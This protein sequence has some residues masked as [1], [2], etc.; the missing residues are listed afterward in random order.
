MGYNRLGCITCL[1]FWVWVIVWVWTIFWSRIGHNYQSL[2][3]V[4]IIQWK[5]WFYIQER[6]I[7][8]MDLGLFKK[9]C[10]FLLFW[11]VFCKMTWPFAYKTNFWKFS[12]KLLSSKKLSFFLPEWFFLVTCIVSFLPGVFLE[13]ISS[14][15]WTCTI[16]LIVLYL[17]IFPF[18]IVFKFAMNFVNFWKK[19][20]LIAEFF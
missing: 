20:S 15:H 7:I 18:A 4:V 3:R 5:E 17:Q 1:D 14:F 9:L 19:F 8:C 13:M 12:F 10:C 16:F 11:T 6:S 2:R